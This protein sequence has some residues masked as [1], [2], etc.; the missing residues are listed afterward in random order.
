MRNLVIF[1]PTTQKSENF[2]S[3]GS[4]R[5]KYTRFEQQKCRG[6]IFQDTEQSCKILINSDLVVSIMAY[7][8]LG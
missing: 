4:F 8:K 5:P 3:M 7:E 1:Q 2:F 6:V